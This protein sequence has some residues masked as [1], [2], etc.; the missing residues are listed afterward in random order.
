LVAIVS[1][2]SPFKCFVFVQIFV[3][4]SF[5]GPL[6]ELDSGWFLLKDVAHSTMGRCHPLKNGTLMHLLVV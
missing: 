4:A 3:D 2:A 1:V 6:D 5:D